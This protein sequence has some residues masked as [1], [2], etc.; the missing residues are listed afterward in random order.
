MRHSAFCILHSALIVVAAF[1]AKAVNA[2]TTLFDFE[3]EAEREAQPAEKTTGFH[4]CFTNAYATSGDYALHYVCHPWFDPGTASPDPTF[5]LTNSVTDWRGFDRLAIDVVSLGQ[6]YGRLKL[7]I[8]GENGSFCDE[9]AIPEKGYRQWIVPLAFLDKVL[10]SSNV[11]KL[12]FWTY[13][14]TSADFSVIID[15]ITLLRKDEEPPAPEGP[16]VGRDIQPLVRQGQEEQR[17]EA[18]N[19]EHAVS[20]ERLRAACGES[21]ISSPGMLLGTATSMEK[22]LP[23]GPF[24][25]KPVGKDGIFVRLAR[26]EHEGVQLIVVPDVGN[27]KGVRVQV[28]G[29][30][31]PMQNAQCTMQNEGTGNGKRGMGGNR[32]TDKPSNRQTFVAAFAA[33]N[34]ACDVTGYVRTEAY[35][36]YRTG[37]TVAATDEAGYVRKAQPPYVGWWPDPI[38]GFLDGVDVKNGDAQS[39]WIRVRCPEN[40]PAGVYEGGLVIT[41][42]GLAPVRVPFRVRINNFAIGRTPALPV[43]VSFAPDVSGTYGENRNWSRWHDNKTPLHQWGRHQDEWVDF[44]ADYFITFD[45]LYHGNAERHFNGVLRL[46]DQGRLGLFNLGYWLYPKSTNEADVAAWRNSVIPRLT[47][48]YAKAKD[49][50]VLDHAYTYGCDE[51]PEQY[52]PAVKIAVDEVKKALPGVPL[53]T[54]AGDG[55]KYGVGTLLSG[56]DWF[57]PIT[58]RYDYE[59]AEASRKVGHKVWHYVCSGPKAPYAN[60]FL[61]GQ[62]IEP[63]LLLGAQALRIKS[64]GFLY[65]AIAQWK[66]ARCIETSPFT[67][68]DPSSYAD[69]HG[70]GQLACVGPDGIPVPTIRLENFRDGLEDYAYAKLL[71][72]KLSVV[73]SSKLKVE[74]DGGE[75][76]NCLTAQPLNSS[77]REAWLRRAKSALAVPRELM[78]SMTNYTDDP[79]VLYRWRDGMADLIEEV[80]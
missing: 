68:W 62:G 15:R 43:I 31:T 70:D 37:Y 39:F 67:D 8:P 47:N 41:A 25:A 40:Q 23:R 54:T 56:I 74:S 48:S 11:A 57:C 65:Y 28:E 53:I 63:R 19:A 69:W 52:Q 17:A 79:A 36:C 10:P 75:N 60:F 21:G 45:R 9:F 66:S 61:E 72:Q 59:R 71:E 46:R 5:T 44:L 14:F 35:P 27:L 26:N 58:H 33:S 2:A 51:V 12:Q 76:L 78:D 73:E 50:G 49:E 38:L 7:S 29:D 16:C 42:E 22:V 32:Q 30:L 18:G 6:G 34:I 77:R 4:V 24:N 64:D 80:Q 3:T 20:V 55:H 13:N 1:A